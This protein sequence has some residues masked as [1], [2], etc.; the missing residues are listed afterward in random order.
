M[1][2]KEEAQDYRYFPEPDLVPVH[3]P[4]ELVERLRGEIGELPGARIAPPRA[5][6]SRSTTRTCS[7]RAGSTGSGPRSSLPAP[8]RRRRRTSSRI[9]SSRRASTRSRSTPAELAEARARPARTI[10]R[11][12]FDEALAQGRG[13]PGFS[14]EPHVAQ[15][16]VVGRRRARS[17]DR[18]GHRGER[19]AGGAVPKRQAGA[20]RLLRRPG[21][22]GDWRQGRP[23]CRERARAREAQ[24]LTPGRGDL[25]RGPVAGHARS[26]QPVSLA[27][28]RYEPDEPD[29]QPRH[30]RLNRV[31]RF[32]PA[33]RSRPAGPALQPKVWTLGALACSEACVNL[34]NLVRTRCRS[35]SR[36]GLSTRSWLRDR[37]SAVRDAEHREAHLVGRAFAPE[38][39]A[40]CE[41][42]RADDRLVGLRVVERARDADRV[43][44]RRRRSASSGSRRPA[45]GRPSAGM[46]SSVCSFAV[47][48]SRTTEMS[49]PRRCMWP[50]T[51]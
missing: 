23:A 19:R 9:S 34:R 33:A 11:A 8:T 3:P 18:A 24:R 5:T 41:L 2:S 48:G 26:R 35:W 16:A 10:P 36:G 17:G 12:A 44:G 7:S 21:D 13:S 50:A 37:S 1:R 15:K 30:R 27:R 42:L 20:A 32:G 31:K 45:S 43:G 47:P 6:R 40:R 49:W 4:E 39:V 28:G 25:S 46:C 14:A 22:E 51:P 38:H 29:S